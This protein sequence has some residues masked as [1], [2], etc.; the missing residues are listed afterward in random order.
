MVRFSG[1]V[2]G[3]KAKIGVVCLLRP[4]NVRSA[5]AL[6]I[7][8]GSGIV[9]QND[10]DAIGVIDGCSQFFKFMFG[11]RLIHKDRTAG[12]N[13]TRRPMRYLAAPATV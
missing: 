1:R 2:T 6:D 7:A 9:L 13:L 4:S 3:L 10:R 5:I 11:E 12:L 8:S